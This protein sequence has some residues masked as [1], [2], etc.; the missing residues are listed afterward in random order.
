[1][2]QSLIS[3]PLNLRNSYG[4]M[5]SMREETGE[6]SSLFVLLKDIEVAPTPYLYI[7]HVTSIF[8]GEV[9]RHFDHL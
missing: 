6:Q 4:I 2:Y 7:D 5:T 1:M 8:M 3:S 9:K